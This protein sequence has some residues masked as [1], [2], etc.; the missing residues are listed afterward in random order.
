[1]SYGQR[2]RSAVVSE[3]TQEVI[4]ASSSEESEVEK[5]RIANLIAF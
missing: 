2:L 5:A 3:E 1:M 4:N